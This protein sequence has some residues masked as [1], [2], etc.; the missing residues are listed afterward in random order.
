MPIRRVVISR[1]PKQEG[2]GVAE[3]LPRARKANEERVY[4][5]MVCPSGIPEVLTDMVFIIYTEKAH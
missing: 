2:S 1:E 5:N 4:E 3:C